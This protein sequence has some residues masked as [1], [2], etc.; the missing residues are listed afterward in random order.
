[1]EVKAF[2]ARDKDGDLYIYT[3]GKPYKCAFV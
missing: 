3:K 2:I 1:M